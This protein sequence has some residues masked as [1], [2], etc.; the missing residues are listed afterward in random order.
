MSGL[1]EAVPD[2]VLRD[3]LWGVIIHPASTP[4]EDDGVN[5]SAGFSA[6]GSKRGELLRLHQVFKNHAAT[7]ILVHGSCLTSGAHAFGMAAVELKLAGA[8]NCLRSPIVGRGVPVG[9]EDLGLKVPQKGIDFG[10]GVVA[11]KGGVVAG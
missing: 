9:M 2:V 10:P 5:L 8:A 11:T 6:A 7:G 1:A 3:W 4:L